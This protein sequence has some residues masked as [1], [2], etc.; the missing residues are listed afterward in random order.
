MIDWG[1]PRTGNRSWQQVPQSH[2]TM[3]P[4]LTAFFRGNRSGLSQSAQPSM[5]TTLFKSG[6]QQVEDA[7][8][9]LTERRQELEQ[10]IRSLEVNL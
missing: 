6:T 3:T 5:E 2:S 4:G 7:V 9:S 1:Y 8:L 10:D